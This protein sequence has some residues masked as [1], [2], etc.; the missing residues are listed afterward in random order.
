MNRIKLA[1]D[2]YIEIDNLNHTLK[3]SKVSETSGKIYEKTHGYYGNVRSAVK[4]FVAAY[5]V[6]Y[7]FTDL[8]SLDEYVVAVELLNAEAVEKITELVSGDGYDTRM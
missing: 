1:G 5:Q 8:E 7:G 3:Q 4:G 2:F 6:E